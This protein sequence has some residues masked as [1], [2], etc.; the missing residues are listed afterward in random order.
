MGDADEQAVANEAFPMPSITGAQPT[1]KVPHSPREAASLLSERGGAG[2]LSK[3]AFWQLLRPPPTPLS[4]GLMLKGAIWPFVDTFSLVQYLPGMNM[5]P[6]TS[7]SAA[8]LLSDWPP[9]HTSLG[10]RQVVGGQAQRGREPFGVR[11]IENRLC[12]THTHAHTENS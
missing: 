5:G 4:K 9:P 7:E 3:C 2:A 6:S 8:C 11:E 12:G 10:E 1:G